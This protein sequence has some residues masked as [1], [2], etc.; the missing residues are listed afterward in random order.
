MTCQ[1][2]NHPPSFPNN[3]DSQ[4]KTKILNCNGVQLAQNGE[5]TLHP[6]NLT[7]LFLIATHIFSPYITAASPRTVPISTETMKTLNK[8][9]NQPNTV[10]HRIRSPLLQHIAANFTTAHNIVA[11]NAASPVFTAP[12]AADPTI[13]ATVVSVPA[14]TRPEPK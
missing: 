12:I 7:F 14:A 11:L 6:C 9:F 8:L 4:A 10:P 5:S 2:C 1:N 13:D 3:L